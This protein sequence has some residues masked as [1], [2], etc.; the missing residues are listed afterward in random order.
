MGLKLCG[1]WQ[2]GTP[3]L[4]SI[5]EACTQLRLLDVTHC[6]QLN[7]PELLRG[8]A[9]HCT[10][11][12]ELLAGGLSDVDDDVVIPMA[13]STAGASLESWCLSGSDISN[14]SLKVI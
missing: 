3:P 9:A 4:L 14:E 6:R 8:V 5:L 10:E 12:R 2:V 11:L 7:G 13:M 1:L